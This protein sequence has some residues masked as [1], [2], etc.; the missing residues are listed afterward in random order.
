MAV[1]SASEAASSRY[2]DMDVE[3]DFVKYGE[4]ISP[5]KDGGVRKIIQVEGDGKDMPPVGSKVRVYYSGK[6]MTGEEFDS[7]VGKN[8][9][10]EF[11]H[12]KGKFTLCC[13]YKKTRGSGRALSIDKARCESH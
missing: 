1:E 5:A 10:F 12:G 8:N 11:E 6:L 7:N 13:F 3:N 2:T 9:P 4:D